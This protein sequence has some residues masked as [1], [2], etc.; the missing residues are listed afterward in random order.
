MAENSKEHPEA[1][2]FFVEQARNITEVLELKHL[3]N[4]RIPVPNMSGDFIYSMTVEVLWIK[5]IKMWYQLEGLN[6]PTVRG[7]IQ[8]I[9]KTF[10]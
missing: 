1:F 3:G 4:Y 9:V 8:H 10:K 6:A 7:K 2:A 5:F